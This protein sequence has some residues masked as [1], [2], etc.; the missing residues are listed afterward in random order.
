[1]HSKKHNI[2]KLKFVTST[3]IKKKK[4]SYIYFKLKHDINKIE[5]CND[6]GWGIFKKSY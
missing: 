5:M 6:Q 1:M 4:L 3:L 2:L